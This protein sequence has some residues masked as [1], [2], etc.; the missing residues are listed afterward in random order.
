MSDCLGIYIE[1]NIIKYAKISKDRKSIKVENYGIKFYDN[2]STAIQNILQETSSSNSLKSTNLVSEKYN[3]FE[4]FSSLSKKDI[5]NSISTVFELQCE[6]KGIREGSLE[7]RYILTNN[8]KKADRLKAIHIST[9]KKDL[10][11]QIQN[12]GKAKLSSVTPLP[13]SIVNIVNQSKISNFAI[14]NMEQK[15]S[16]TIV[17][18]GQV[19]KIINL[20]NGMEGILE[21]LASKL[22]SYSK[23]YEVLKNITL[24]MQVSKETYEDNTEY[25]EYVMPRLYEIVEECKN[26]IAEYE[27][28]IER[29][30]ITGTGAIIN[31]IDLYFSNYFESVK[32]EILKPYFIENVSALQVNI[33]DYIEVN[34]AIAIAT[35][36][37]GLGI[38]ELNFVKNA[39]PDWLTTEIDFPKLSNSKNKKSGSNKTKI[40]KNDLGTELDFVDGFLIRTIIGIF[41]ILI[42]YV[43]VSKSIVNKLDEKHHYTDEYI[44]NIQKQ[45]QSINEDKSNLQSKERL[46]KI[47]SDNLIKNRDE[48]ID[49]YRKINDIPNFLNE[50]M[51]IIPKEVT[52]LSMSMPSQED[53]N[54]QKVQIQVQSAYYEQLGAF[55]V[56]LKGLMDSVQTETIKQE[57]GST[58]IKIT[59]ELK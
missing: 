28:N 35:E 10:S 6:E 7:T 36:G 9:D 31:N 16:I 52:I 4:V 13:I 50:I 30:Y 56:K 17:E 26:N 34:S 47:A 15:S 12:V 37:L 23:A 22:N 1:N 51:H 54:P 24:Y 55:V 38:K 48:I 11:R 29:I 45:I 40:I 19:S 44:N 49:K 59:G 58:T 8:I 21:Q 33:K 53:S 25:L 5:K 39:I 57:V 27:S 43:I 46:Y 3:Y 41:I 2:I 32:C 14:V 20:D 18:N 42:V